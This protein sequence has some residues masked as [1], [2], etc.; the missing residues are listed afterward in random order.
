MQPLIKSPFAK[1]IDSG[2]LIF[3]S[4]VFSAL[5]LT[6]LL[7]ALQ[8]LALQVAKPCDAA[9]LTAPYNAAICDKVIQLR[10]DGAPASLSDGAALHVHL[11][12]M[13]EVLLSR[14]LHRRAEYALARIEIGFDSEKLV[15]RSLYSCIQ[16][17]G[18]QRLANVLT[19]F[20]NP[21]AKV[22]VPS[23]LLGSDDFCF[24]AVD[25]VLVR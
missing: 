4:D 5:L 1:G 9:S 18:F 7:V 19:F 23:T 22:P 25:R 3:D 20:A 21:H 24:S 12:T 2:L 10:L 15:L 13:L 14:L 17:L 6:I 11:P 8:A 16:V